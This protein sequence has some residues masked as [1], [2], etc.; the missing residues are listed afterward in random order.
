[1]TA[2]LDL[3]LVSG[4]NRG[5]GRALV[6]A[7]A[8]RG[9]TVY[10]G[11]RD[12]RMAETVSAA[13]RE[14]GV[15]EVIP[16]ALDVRSGESVAAAAD[17][18]GSRGVDLLFNNAG[19]LL[20]DPLLLPPDVTAAADDPVARSIET[21]LYGPLRLV[22][23][24]A[25]GMVGRGRGRIINVSSGWASFGEGLGPGPYAISKVALNALTLTLAREL[26]AEVTVNAVDPGWVATD[27]GGASATKSPESAAADILEVALGELGRGTG[28]FFYE[29]KPRAW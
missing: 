24:F 8:A 7:L 14:R 23:A 22:R 20:E 6:E 12:M 15:G 26:P 5:I 3:A 19:I 27:M 16:I 1:M 25:P 10:L 18:L 4:G 17:Q 13:L 9:F 29:G 28:G 21:N 2:D 11:A